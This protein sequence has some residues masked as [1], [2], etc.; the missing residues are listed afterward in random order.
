MFRL[1]PNCNVN[2]CCATLGA[3]LFVGCSILDRGRSAPNS[4]GL[5]LLP[6]KSVA[7]LLLISSHL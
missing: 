6:V 2:E 1:G 5:I 4:K 7:K 3:L